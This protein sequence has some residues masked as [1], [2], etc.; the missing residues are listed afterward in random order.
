[1][2]YQL[3]TCLECGKPLGSSQRK[4][5]G[6]ESNEQVYR[7]CRVGCM[8]GWLCTY[9]KAYRRQSTG[10]QQNAHQWGMEARV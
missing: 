9:L 3:T 5:I 7:F 6:P 4:F 2:A 10:K 8:T 1:M